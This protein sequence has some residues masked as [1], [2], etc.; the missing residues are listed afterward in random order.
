MQANMSNSILK[1]PQKQLLNFNLN[2]GPLSVF[3]KRLKTYEFF[4]NFKINLLRR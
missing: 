2:Y 3:S 4:F 1:K